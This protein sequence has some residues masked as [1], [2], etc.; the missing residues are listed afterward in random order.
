[1]E[2]SKSEWIKSK[3][4]R[5]Q[6]EQRECCYCK[7]PGK[8]EDLGFKHTNEKGKVDWSICFWCTKKALDKTLDKVTEVRE[9]ATKSL[10]K[11]IYC[12]KSMVKERPYLL[13]TDKNGNIRWCVCFDCIKRAFDNILKEG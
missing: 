7:K 6:E 4:G 2:E 9:F 8:G 10:D 12:E 13:N 3:D 5:L 1:M 11:C